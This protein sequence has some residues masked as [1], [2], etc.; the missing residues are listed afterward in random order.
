MQYPTVIL[1]FSLALT[2]GCGGDSA[3]TP[4][5][6]TPA[7]SSDLEA[8]TIPLDG[9][10]LMARDGELYLFD[11]ATGLTSDPVATPKGVTETLY[12]VAP[13]GLSLVAQIASGPWVRFA[14][15]RGER[16][17]LRELARWELAG[18]EVRF[19]PEG[20]RM[21]IG[22]SVVDLAAGTVHACGGRVTF[23]GEGRYVCDGVLFDDGAAIAEGVVLL[24]EGPSPDGQF[25]DVATHMT[26]AQRERPVSFEFD[27]E[28][29]DW[30]RT[31][32]A[33]GTIV[34]SQ[35]YV[36]GD[37]VVEEDAGFVTLYRRVN[38]PSL[39]PAGHAYDPT[40]L[41]RTGEWLSG[42]ADE[43][44]DVREFE[45]LQAFFSDGEGRYYDHVGATAGGSLVFRVQSHKLEDDSAGGTNVINEM[46]VESALVEVFPD[47]DV[48][49]FRGYRLSDGAII[50][51]LG[52]D[53][54]RELAPLGVVDFPGGDWLF[55]T[56]KDVTLGAA[57]FGRDDWLGYLGGEPVAFA[58]VGRM[59]RDGKHFLRARFATEF[60]VPHAVCIQPVAR[61]SKATCM[62][63]GSDG[64]PIEIVGQGLDPKYDSAP[65]SIRHLSRVAAW[66]GAPL[67]LHGAHFGQS[68]TL[69]IG[70]VAV[71]AS[72]IARW[73]PSRID[74]DMVDA[75]GEVVVTTAH[76]ASDGRGFS[77]ARTALVQTP[78]DGMSRE[79]TRL[80]QGLNE[81]TLGDIPGVAKSGRKV[82]EIDPALKTADGRWIVR[83]VGAS[84]A[85]EHAIVLA[86]NGY[87]RRW[88]VL[89]EDRS[90]DPGRWQYLF[91]F[92][93]PVYDNVPSFVTLA[94]ELF[95]LAINQNLAIGGRVINRGLADQVVGG[96][97]RIPDFWRVSPDGT[98]WVLYLVNNA[99]SGVA[100]QITG[101][102]RPEDG[103]WGYP[104]GAPGINVGMVN[105][106]GVA[107][108]GDVVLL[109]GGDPNALGGGPGYKLSHDGGKTFDPVVT[110][111]SGDPFVEPVA[112]P[113]GASGFFVTFQGLV[114]KQV[115]GVHRIDVDGTLSRDI[116]PAPPLK[117]RLAYAGARG[118]PFDVVA[119]SGR[120]LVFSADSETLV[121]TTF[122]GTWR[123]LPTATDATH[124][125]SIFHDL[126]DA[127][128]AAVVAVRDDGTVWRAT[129]ASGWTD[130]AEVDLGIDLLVPANADVLAVGVAPD[131]RMLVSARLFDGRPG[132]A[133]NT[134]WPFAAYGLLAGPMR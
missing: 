8:T 72:A 5:G 132:A 129:D 83:S 80:G 68:G 110:S 46:F 102:T 55:Q 77:L 50:A 109:V 48:R 20:D 21:A 99:S 9:Y 111:A 117:T 2:L 130:W 3:Q 61:G 128:R 1:S 71:P 94:G 23:L 12:G 73:T 13:D 53:G 34:T 91:D 95:E 35:N 105:G 69:T 56:P 81:V 4:D 7:G 114:G 86:S 54:Q 92:A 75:D 30:T 18:G 104:Q 27:S 44:T 118:R 88:N 29:H 66:P 93:A 28:F 107:A 32:L 108:L 47:G 6:Q 14:I 11:P 59:S 45:G 40:I 112:V 42:E 100:S 126:H 51:G 22:V 36:H 89:L 131:G 58:G 87:S 90:A 24:P 67:V 113:D 120:L 39:P 49:G 43:V 122:D 60:G 74:F 134:P 38:S 65:P 85:E 98:T 31:Q 19:D 84:P 79:V 124:V 25:A 10:L 101:W 133:A 119:D 76:G 97:N 82:A 103:K 70:D 26:G 17:V 125:R 78:F 37:Y 63:Q 96:N 16:P 33:D 116:L 106:K 52:G 64:R 41:F 121:A 127:G 115:S 57:L 62:P 123:T 15:E